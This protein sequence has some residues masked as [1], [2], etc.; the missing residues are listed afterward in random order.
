MIG[1]IPPGLLLILGALLAPLLPGRIR[2][3]YLLALPMIGLL[4]LIGLE[5]GVYGSF[6]IFD[7]EL[8]PVRVDKLSLLFGYIFHIAAILTAVYALH[9][10][11]RV[12]QVTGMM[13]AGS[14]IG[15]VFAGD[16]ITLFVYWEGT[17]IASVFLIW[18]RRE[19]RAYRAGMR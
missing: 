14:A 6:R 2:Q 18:A 5:H 4:G 11:D 7:Y 10:D 16:L 8:L 9:V 15:A 3:V 13:Y 19:E 17:A 12:Q 1:S